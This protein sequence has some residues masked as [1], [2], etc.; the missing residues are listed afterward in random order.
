MSPKVLVR[1]AGLVGLIAGLLLSLAA[2]P[3][4]PAVEGP[5]PV[6]LYSYAAL[7]PD[8]PAEGIADAQRE[9][10]TAQVR[11]ALVPAV[12]AALAEIGG[13]V[14]YAA[15]TELAVGGTD[16]TVWPI[17]LTQLPVPDGQADLIAASFGYAFR[18]ARVLV[19]DFAGT[20]PAP[21]YAVVSFPADS[22]TARL[23]QAFV[24]HAAAAAPDL[25]MGYVS[26]GDDL[27][28]F[29]LA[30]DGPEGG[31]VGALATAAESFAERPATLLV[32]GHAA[33]WR[34]GNDWAAAPQGDAY[35][36]VIHAGLG[37]AEALRLLAAL[38][39]VQRDHRDLLRRAA[40]LYGWP[41]GAVP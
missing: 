10:V 32:G 33:T 20:D 30:E 38:G 12:L 36:G 6:L 9:A 21:A 1:P 40:Q 39:R 23:T 28:L 5:P 17:L 34:V 2:A 8:L 35:R 4:A 26:L 37:D 25:A 19:G 15:R 11:D 24:D 31:F 14:P 16:G 41:E 7:P 3:P 18:Q 27:L 13:I 22:L 29:D